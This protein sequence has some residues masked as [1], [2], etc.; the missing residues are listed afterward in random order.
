MNSCVPVWHARLDE[1][2]M[3]AFNYRNFLPLL[4]L[5]HR[6]YC[7]LVDINLIFRVIIE[8]LLKIVFLA[9]LLHSSIRLGL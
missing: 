3:I 9:V 2:T 8:S 7:N 6:L 4:L 1:F 5:R